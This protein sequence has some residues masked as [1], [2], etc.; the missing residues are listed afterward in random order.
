[1]S[2][3]RR[4][5]RILLEDMP[6]RYQTI[7]NRNFVLTLLSCCIVVISQRAPAVTYYVS[8]SGDDSNSGTSTQRAW[9][10]I[11]KINAVD[12]N[13]GD[14]VL[15]EGGHDYEGNLLLTGKDAGTHKQPIVIGSYGSGRARIKAGDGSGVTV[16]NAGGV[17][18]KNLILTGED[19]RT[20]VGSGIKIVNELPNNQKLQYIEV[21]NIEASS[22]GR[23]KDASPEGL[24]TPNGCGIFVGGNAS[25][26]SKSGYRNVRITHCVTYQNEYYGILTSGY[27][28]DDPGTYANAN[29]YVGY[30]TMYDNPGD[31]EYFRNHSGSGILMEDVD[32]GIIEYCEA[33]NNG[34]DCKCKIGGPVGIWAAVANKIIIQH[35]ESHHNKTGGRADGGGF[36]FDGGTTNSVLQYNY[37]H[38][39]EGP[40]YLICS[41]KNAPHSFNNNTVRY[42]A[43]VNDCQNGHHAAITFWTGSPEED[44]ICNT[45]IYNNTIYSSMGPAISF[46][47]KKG[48][49]KTTVCNN[50]FITA[51]GHK[52]VSGNPDTSMAT[53]TNNVYWSVDGKCDIAGYKSL[54][55]WRETVGQ[56]MLNGRPFGLVVDPQLMDIGTSVTI[57]DPTKLHALTAYRLRKG[58]PLINAGVDLRSQFDIDPG[59][60]DFYGNPI[61]QGE[62]FDIGAHEITLENTPD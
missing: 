58:S 9:R 26:K 32:G 17:V 11:G 14:K 4:S 34:Y 57:G 19:Y 16:R 33:Y 46:W 13:P 40:G 42:N 51:G 48:I 35:C 41:Y 37:S 52:L 53:F 45:W 3:G 62:G 29:V 1:M 7:K 24:Q 50:I 28:Q 22:F 8:P 20:N 56:E 10:T 54:E 23:K 12:L 38:D 30:C 55:A 31:P 47:V 5:N 59:N 2:M 39:N 18:V 43:S 44:P 49:H 21:H 27:W 61:P 36:D 25:D 60:R 15:I 6:W